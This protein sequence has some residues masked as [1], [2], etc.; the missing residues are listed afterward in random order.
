MEGFSNFPFNHI[1][2]YE[3]PDTLNYMLIFQLLCCKL[4]NILIQTIDRM[5]FC[6]TPF[7]NKCRQF[8]LIIGSSN[9]CNDEHGELEA[10]YNRKNY[11]EIRKSLDTYFNLESPPVEFLFLDF[12]KTKAIFLVD[13]GADNNVIQLN[14]LN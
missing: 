13:T 7:S 6:S 5:K 12:N 1:P 10:S 8:K 14:T 11:N 9:R 4:Q 3:Y 2:L